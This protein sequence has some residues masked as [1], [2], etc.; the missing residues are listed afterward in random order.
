MNKDIEAVKDCVLDI[1]DRLQRINYS[2]DYALARIDYTL[3]KVDEDR[4]EIYRMKR[5]LGIE[6][7]H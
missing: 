4:K 5:E 3:S 2:M 6:I 1:S 7:V